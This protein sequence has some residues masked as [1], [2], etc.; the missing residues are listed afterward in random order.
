MAQVWVSCLRSGRPDAAQCRRAEGWITAALEKHA[1][2]AVLTLALANLRDLQDRPEEAE[3]IYRDLLKRDENN[4]IACNN[5]AALKAF[6]GKEVGDGLDVIQR[7]IQV[8]GPRPKL[9]DTRA[10]VYM[11]LGRWADAVR[12]LEEVVSQEPNPASY[13]RLARAHG[14][15]GNRKAALGALAKARARDGGLKLSDLHPLER[16]VYEKFVQE[17]EK[18][19]VQ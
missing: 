9:L 17:L 14:M 7:A 12:D 1:G 15:A 8:G 2:S 10:C 11:A 19:S 5:L 3:S 4:L 13:L 6:E 16:P 18:N